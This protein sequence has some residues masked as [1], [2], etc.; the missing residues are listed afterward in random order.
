VYNSIEFN[1]KGIKMHQNTPLETDLRLKA[2]AGLEQEVAKDMESP[3][4][5]LGKLLGEVIEDEE[6]KENTDEDTEDTND[7]V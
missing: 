7:S 1:P 3:D 2:A 5:C 4:K 6:D